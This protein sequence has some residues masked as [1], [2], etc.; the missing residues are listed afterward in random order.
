MR[1]RYPLALLAP[2][3]FTLSAAAADWPPGAKAEFVTQCVAGAQSSHGPAQLQAYCECAA[4]KVIEE[5][6]EA[7]MQ[8]MNRQS[9]P[10]P[11]LQQRLV[12]ASSPCKARLQP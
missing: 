6:S 7:E 3:A 5:F 11:A 4:D 10:D 8:A 12:T 2:L 1:Y 9:P